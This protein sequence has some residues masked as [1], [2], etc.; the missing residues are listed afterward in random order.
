LQGLLLQID[1]PE[2]IHHKT[3]QPDAVVNLFDADRLTGQRGAEIDLL[4]VQA[5]APAVAT[6]TV[7]S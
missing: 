4:A 7:R 2:I 6:T 5:Q 3:D 1:I